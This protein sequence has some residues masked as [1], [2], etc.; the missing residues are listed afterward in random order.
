MPLITVLKSFYF[1]LVFADKVNL[2]DFLFFNTCSLFY[3]KWIK[4][5]WKYGEKH[6]ETQT[7]KHL[8]VAKHSKYSKQSIKEHH[9]LLLLL[10]FVTLAL[11]QTPIPPN[12]PVSIY[13]LTRIHARTHTQTH[14]LGIKSLEEPFNFWS[15]TKFQSKLTFPS[16]LTFFSIFW[17]VFSHTRILIWAFCKWI[18]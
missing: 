13:T 18:F 9:Q 10:S 4:T 14:T 17:I 7:N 6:F 8:C 5:P 11:S 3:W 1:F 16:E 2:I 15:V 12:V